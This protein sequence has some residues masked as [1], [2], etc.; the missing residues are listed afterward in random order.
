M[1]E[2]TDAWQ[3]ELVRLRRALH[4]CAEPSGQETRTAATIKRFL[5]EHTSLELHDCGAGFYG[6]HREP[7]VSAAG[8]ALRAD[9]DALAQEDGHAAHLCGHD[10]H[11]AAL[12]G[13][14]LLLEGRRVGRDVFLLFQSAEETGKGAEGCLAFFE[15]EAVGEI[16]GAHN[17]PGYPF[18]QVFTRAGTFACASRGLAVRLTGVGA[19]AAYPE[20]G[21]SPAQALGK[22]LIALPGLE[23]R[24]ERSD[25]ARC[26]IIGA[27][28]GEQ[29]FGSAPGSAELW[30]TLRAERDEPLAALEAMVL[31]Q[32]AHA[33]QNARL[34]Y[35]TDVCDPFPATVNDAGCAEKV[36]RVCH[37]AQL[38]EPMRWSEDF[39]HYL[40]VCKGAFFGIGAGECQPP[41]HNPAYEYP[42]ALLEPTVRAFGKILD[43]M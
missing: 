21:I 30:I 1:I 9:Y 25:G 34:G 29:A 22:L 32:I 20:L 24:F 39:G 14:A 37:G 18:G 5:T 33:A 15:R 12:C 40:R 8:I 7:G 3:A 28:L 43:I 38:I 35:T 41:L 17:L 11:A 6:V 27:R 31:E 4:A 23:D 19:H 42:D 36:L 2:L 13:V 10:G 26:T 16:Y